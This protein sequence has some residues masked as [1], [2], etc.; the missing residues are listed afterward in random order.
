[1]EEFTDG[2]RVAD[3]NET[4]QVLGAG[5]GKLRRLLVRIG[6]VWS[7]GIARRSRGV[8]DDG[9]WG[10]WWVEIGLFVPLDNV[11][12][13]TPHQDPT[14]LSRPH[15][16]LE[17]YERECNLDAPKT[18]YNLPYQKTQVTKLSRG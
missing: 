16:P 12:A 4:I 1:M 3:L 6:R 14:R 5:A 18:L 10:L 13:P 9:I 2:L 8:E 7:D 15:R 17:T 11:R